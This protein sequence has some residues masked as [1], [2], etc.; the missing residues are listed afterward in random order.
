[1]PT[2]VVC[3]IVFNRAVGA[4][5]LAF[6]QNDLLPELSSAVKNI[7]LMEAPVIVLQLNDKKRL[8][9]SIVYI[10]DQFVD[11]FS[12]VLLGS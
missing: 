7:D 2:S 6:F 3:L 12:P 8:N 9:K 4:G 5:L 11:A 1:M 10:N